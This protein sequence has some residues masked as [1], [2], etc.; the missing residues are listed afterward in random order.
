M[1]GTTMNYIE[2]N[3]TIVHDGQKFTASGAIVNDIFVIAY[4]GKNGELNN[5]HGTPSGTYRITSTWKTPRSYISN[6]M[7]Q[8]EAKIDGVIYTGRSCGIGM[9]FKGK[10]KSRN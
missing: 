4:L 2:Q 1:E 10:R 8:V 6:V 3:C 5:C 9:A 7:C